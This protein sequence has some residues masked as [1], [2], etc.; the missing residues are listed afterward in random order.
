MLYLILN[1]TL[2]QV[3]SKCVIFWH[4]TSDSQAARVVVYQVLVC[5]CCTGV[6]TRMYICARTRTATRSSPGCSYCII[7]TA[8]CILFPKRCS[9]LC[10]CACAAVVAHHTL[11]TWY[12][13]CVKNKQIKNKN[14]NFGKS[15]HVL[16]ARPL[17]TKIQR[18]TYCVFTTALSRET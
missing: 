11:T 8:G 2:N 10:D 4:S 13:I 7:T 14:A 5:A 18:K 1:Y 16:L 17:Y 9:N 3:L 15:C 12:S 6:H